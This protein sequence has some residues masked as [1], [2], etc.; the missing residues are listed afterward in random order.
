MKNLSLV[1]VTMAVLVAIT[2]SSFV[3]AESEVG[4]ELAKLK[5]IEKSQLVVNQPLEFAQLT[6]QFDT[7][8]D[9]A[10]SRAEVSVG[11]SK[12]LTSAFEQI[13]ANGDG[14]IEQ[15]EFEAFRQTAQK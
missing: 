4:Q 14:V 1:K 7:D 12:I 10:L 15:N 9:G 13:D 2:I 3:S 5:E 6:A 11:Q 8:K